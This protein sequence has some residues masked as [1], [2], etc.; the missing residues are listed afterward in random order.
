[1]GISDEHLIELQQ[2]KFM[3]ENPSIA[4][5][6]ANVL[7]TPIGK[8]MALLP[9]GAQDQI[10]AISEKSLSSALKLALF[11]LGDEV[12]SAANFT[13]KAGSAFTGAIGGAFG[14][15]ALAAELPIS[16]TIMLRSIADI[17][18]S[19]GENLGTPEA[20]LACMEV[21]AL[22][23]T[24]PGDDAAESGYFGVRTAL[25]AAVTEALGYAASAGAVKETAPAMIRLIGQ[26]AARF[27]I[28]VTEKAAA[29]AVPV[30]GAAGG[31]IINILFIDHFQDA[32]KGHFV[33]R[34]LE[35]IY[36]QGTVLEAYRACACTVG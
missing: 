4:A 20:K 7:A 23:G 19:E 29:Q 8:G 18:R 36:G 22:G 2:A 26:I 9:Q 21:F 32:A 16:T 28:P 1:M 25:A 11:T 34:R 33:I 5:R 14:L 35:R 6:F 27:S 24:S 30:V 10:L 12:K 13:H 17:A 15:P 3:L 31:A